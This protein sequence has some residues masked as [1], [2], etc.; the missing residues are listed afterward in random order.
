VDA[1][2]ELEARIA[3]HPADRYPVQNATASFHLG[4]LLTDEGRTAEAVEALR[5]S[6]ALFGGAGLRTEH[7]KAL[8]ALGAALR[9]AGD[10]PGAEASLRAAAAAF[11]ELGLPLEEG[12]AL[13]NV[14]L[15]TRD[16]EALQVARARF[17]A[18]GETRHEAAAARE[19][20]ALLLERGEPTEA[21]P[22]LR[23][24][25]ALAERVGDLAGLGAA[26]NGLGL[27]LL[28]LGRVEDAAASFRAAA[29]AHGRGV[30]PAEHAMAK[31]NLALACERAGDLRRARLAARQALAVASAPAPVRAQ[32]ESLLARVPAERGDLAS[33]LAE[34]PAEAR[35]VIAREELVRWAEAS[36]MERRAEAAAW[37]EHATPDL[38]EPLL[39]ALLELPPPAM[40]AIAAD[41]SACADE[42][43]RTAI[44]RASA[45]FPVPQLLR[46]QEAFAWS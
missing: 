4:A 15:V 34:E 8:N 26:A 21:E 45:R 27:A 41:L 16:P 29:G 5:R 42:P 25:L 24:A 11:A 30:R 33:V 10:E 28:A 38:A 44:E 43:F 13:H 40:S 22:L 39:G 9:L 20:G 2:E 3:Q 14:G 35:L 19:L 7:A 12:A 46:L 23:E 6:A 17:A 1:I 37:V 32:A 18:A 31:A 36:P